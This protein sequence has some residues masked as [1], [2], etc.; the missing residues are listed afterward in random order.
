MTEEDSQ[1]HQS[2][3]KAINDS[4]TYIEESA[5]LTPAEPADGSEK[6]STDPLQQARADYTG[7]DG[8]AQNVTA[9]QDTFAQIQKIADVLTTAIVGA[10]LKV[11]FA[12]G[13]D[14]RY[15]FIDVENN[16]KSDG[17]R[18]FYLMLSEPSGTTTISASSSCAMTIIDDEEIANTGNCDDCQELYIKSVRAIKRPFEIKLPEKMNKEYAEIYEPV[19]VKIRYKVNKDDSNWEEEKILIYDENGEAYLDSSHKLEYGYYEVTPVFQAKGNVIT[20]IV[21]QSEL[22]NFDT[23]YGLF[24]TK[25]VRSKTISDKKYNEYIVYNNAK[26]GNIYSLSV[27]PLKNNVYPVW[28][29]AG[30]TNQYSGEVFY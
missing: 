22:S 28:K 8:E 16:M 20:V 3:V 10:N 1:L 13:E 2:A 29:V 12:E 11:D 7:I 19:G 9:S 21:A 6:V 23:S 24:S 18:Y 15:I 27:R 25:A 17:D 14:S 30:E 5:G 26:Y 4:I